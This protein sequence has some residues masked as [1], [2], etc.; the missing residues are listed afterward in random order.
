LITKL[1]V[2]LLIFDLDGTLAETRQDLA[3]AVNYALHKLEKVTLDVPTIA[4]YVGNGV[5][6]LLERSLG[7][8]F[9]PQEYEKAWQYFHEHY[10]LHLVDNTYL[11]PGIKEILEHF[12]AKKMAVLSNKSHPYTVTMVERLGISPYFKLVMGSQDGFERK[13]SPKM[14]LHILEQLIAA[15]ETTVIIGDTSNDIEAGKAAGIHTC[16]VTFGYRLIDEITP[17]RP[18]FMVNSA[19]ELKTLFD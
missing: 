3:N 14:V 15:P 8:G 18:E 1:K 11:Y 10:S 2:D 4:S 13:P 17:F 6:K 5:G 12:S 7:E 9:T 16:A 19:A